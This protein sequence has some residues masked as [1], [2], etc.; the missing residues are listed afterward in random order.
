VL[1]ATGVPGLGTPKL[2]GLVCPGAVLRLGAIEVPGL[3]TPKLP[4][5]TPGCPGNGC[6]A[7]GLVPGNPGSGCSGLGGNCG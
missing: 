1:G 6:G 3:G 5:L 7:Y 4:G 2:P